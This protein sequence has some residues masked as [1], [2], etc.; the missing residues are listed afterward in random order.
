MFD[1]NDLRPFL[2]VGRTGTTA[3]AARQLGISQPTVVRRI[4]ALECALGGRLFLHRRDGYELSSFGKSLFAQAEAVE[5]A[6]LAFEEGC[7]AGLRSALGTLKVTVP[8]NLVELLLMPAVKRFSAHHPKVEVQLLGTDR[9]VDIVRGEADIAVRAGIRPHE[10]TLV[11]RSVARS[12][13]AAYSSRAYAAANGPPT[14]ASQLQGHSLLFAEPPLS[15]IPPFVWL[16]RAANGA[17]V[18]SRSSSL[19]HLQAAVAA[20][21]GVSL[22]PCIVADSDP[23]LVRC[24]GPIVDLDAEIWLIVRAELRDSPIARAML[25]AIVETVEE[26]LPL[27]EGKLKA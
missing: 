25:D 15:A 19:S 7:R 8:E 9:P 2:A 22:L 26:L 23:R 14:E 16:D 1:W 6:A 13:W 24:F 20:G 11:A 12:A 3:G 18:V 4:E 5:A 21:F 27:F 10:G 17:H